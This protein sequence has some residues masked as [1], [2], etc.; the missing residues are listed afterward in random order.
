MFPSLLRIWALVKKELLAALKDPRSRVTLF[1]PPIVQSLVFGYAATYD[2]TDVPY[3]VV[4]RDRT[5]AS[6]QLLARFD[7]S[8]IFRRVASADRVEDAT[9]RIDGRDALLVLQIDRDFERRLTAGLGAPVQAITDGRNSNTAGTALDYVSTIV[10]DFN[11]AWRAEHGTPRPAIEV[12]AR[13]WYN[14]NLETRWNMI[15]GLIGTLTML[16]TLLL[17]ALSVAR[18]REQG[19]FDQLLVTPFRPP[20]IMAGKALAAVLVGQAQ[21]ISIIFVAQLW[22]RIP[23]AGSYG[24]LFVGMTAFVFAAVGSGLFVSSLS[25]TTQQALLY[26]FCVLLPAVLLSGLTTPIAAMPKPLQYGTY[27]NPLRYAVEIAQRLY[28]EQVGLDRVWPDLW[29]M[30]VI[31]A[32][33]LTAAS[34]M[35]RRIT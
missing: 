17:A 9:D 2:L 19:T 27:L 16:Q 1:V 21:A 20:E 33:T 26:S 11:Q 8:G 28:L 13:Y 29:P 34:F 31:A 3:V 14:P 22:F 4:D 7:G 24:A 23:F 12:L 6:R 35:F 18:E 25:S 15:P 10:S 30:L 32:V 5:D